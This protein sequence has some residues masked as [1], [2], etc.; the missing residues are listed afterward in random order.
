[1]QSKDQQQIE[2]LIQIIDGKLIEISKAFNRH[3][4]SRSRLPLQK[5][6]NDLL[7]SRLE[8]SAELTKLQNNPASV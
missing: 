4:D 1:M 6:M 7:D 5:E 3:S 2:F 8:L